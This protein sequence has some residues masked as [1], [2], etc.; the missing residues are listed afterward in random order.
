MT[1]DSLH[2]AA[3]GPLQKTLYHG[4]IVHTPTLG[5]LEVLP[6]AWVG[7]DEKGTIAFIDTEGKLTASQVAETH[8]WDSFD[9]DVF[10]LGSDPTRFWF[11]G[12][13]D[14]HIHAPQFPNN[15]IFGNT[16]LLEWL[17]TYTFP[18]ES[19]FKDVKVASEIY[20]RVI[21]RTLANGTTC[22][23]YYGTI[24][25]D[26]TNILAKEAFQQGQRALIGK[27][28]MDKESPDH[29]IETLDSW[30]SSQQKVL[31]YIHN[32]DPT[33]SVIAPVLTPRFAGSCTEKML[34]AVGKLREKG[35]YYCQTHLS[36]NHQEIE[37]ILK[38]F[39]QYKSYTEIYEK[40]NLLSRKTILAHCIHLSEDEKAT[41]EKFQCGVS[42]CPTSNSSIT[43][44]EARVRWLMDGG[45]QVSLGSDCS[46]GFSPSILEVAKHALLVSRHLV[47]KTGAEEE[48]LSTN[49]VLYLATMG[50]AQVMGVES[51]LGSFAVGKKWECQLID[52]GLTGS[53]VDLFKFQI[54]QWGETSSLG[55]FQN[56]VD[57]WV[58][59]GDDRNVVKVYVNGRCVVDKQVKPRQ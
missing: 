43:S 46:G 59:N 48:K 41:L 8:Q 12:F 35:D 30:E 22:A 2:S 1:I 52:L 42:H 26:A 20:Q 18:L 53:K 23:S 49:E 54:P 15:G 36:E 55:K 28:C 33:G 31:D 39:P 5:A 44:G 51:Q 57:K 11:P 14:T 3:L 4:N 6:N 16:T 10:E 40:T 37:W 17:E 29:Y 45:V 58:F 38:Q 7:V 19:S 13:F 9:L 32:V 47:M 24:H 21:G 25:A 50:G 56:L 27:C 34:L